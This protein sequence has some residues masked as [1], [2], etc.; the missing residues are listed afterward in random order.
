MVPGNRIQLHNGSRIKKN[1]LVHIVHTIY[2]FACS[3]QLKTWTDHSTTL[4]E[5]GIFCGPIRCQLQNILVRK[6]RWMDGW[7]PTER[8]GPAV[9][10]PSRIPEGKI[11]ALKPREQRVY[12]ILIRIS[13]HIKK[14]GV[15]LGPFGYLWIF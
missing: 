11:L 6:S 4:S 3:R 5:G 13:L 14:I 15:L 9:K 12:S 10:E 2:F 7:K 1:K 8:P